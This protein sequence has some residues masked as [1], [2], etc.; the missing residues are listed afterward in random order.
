MLP[1]LLIGPLLLVWL[2]MARTR[3]VRWPVAACLAALTAGA[4]L[5]VVA[6]PRG[7]FEASLAALVAAVTIIVVASVAEQR[8]L[9]SQPQP[10][11]IWW[12]RTVSAVLLM[13]ALC[14]SGVLLNPT[15]FAPPADKVLPMPAG[16]SAT[17]DPFDDGDCGSGSCSRTITV[18]GRPGQSGDDLRAEVERH[19]RARG[20]GTEC[21]PVGWLLDRATECLSLS[22]EADHLTIALSGNRGAPGE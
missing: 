17:V 13:A 6:F 19:V 16:L 8:R 1:A 2:P 10:A 14:L 22:A 7:L 12:L 3:R 9:R 20:W 21:R 5:L 15:P 4:A 11:R 18:T